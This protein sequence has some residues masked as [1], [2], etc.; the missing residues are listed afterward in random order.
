M[1]SAPMAE[2][3]SMIAV[4]GNEAAARIAHRLSEVDRDLPDHALHV[5]G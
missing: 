5:D 1:L 4:D 3:R 2:G